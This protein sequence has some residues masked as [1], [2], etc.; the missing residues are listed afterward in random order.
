MTPPEL[1]GDVLL[2]LVLVGFLIFFA[3]SW[4]LMRRSRRN[5]LGMDSTLNSGNLK[6]LEK[7]Q[8]LTPEEMKRVR[9]A[10]ARQYLEEQKAREESETAAKAGVSAL[11][12][13]A[14]RLEQEARRRAEE[15]QREASAAEPAAAPSPDP[16]PSAAP[17]SPP[18][19]ERKEPA[20]ARPEPSPVPSKPPVENA[21]A[22]SL[23]AHLQPMIEKPTGEL[24]DLRNAGFLNEDDFARILR[25]R[26]EVP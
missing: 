11:A 18:A 13:E 17:P 24:E 16:A 5:R 6:V 20:P 1:S 7:K 19:E 26:G 14:E 8:L 9:E 2:L 25:A 4:H 10:M 22:D 3:V 23:P 12:V 15:K 21:H